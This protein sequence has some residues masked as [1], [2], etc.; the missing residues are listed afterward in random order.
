[1]VIK[2]KKSSGVVI[3]KNEG[4]VKISVQCSAV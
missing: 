2:K 3:S 1:M 4:F